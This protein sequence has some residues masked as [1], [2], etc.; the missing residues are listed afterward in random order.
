MADEI[1]VKKAK[2]SDFE[3]FYSLFQKT[4]K[5]G[6]FLY[7]P[8]SVKTFET[9]LPKATIR[10]DIGSGKRVLFL[11]YIN[12]NLAGY[13]LTNDLNGGVLFGHWLAVDRDFQKRGVA[14]K[15][16]EFWQKYAIAE[17]AHMLELFTTKNDVEFYINRGFILAGEL[18]DSYY[19]IDH[20]H[21]YKTLRKSDESRFLKKYEKK[22]K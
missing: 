20:F 10:K 19:G 11:A 3:D 14:S 5:E 22:K 21:F 13:L 16:L 12:S 15:L 17:G 8:R 1:I 4:L 9:D 18:P 2:V 7:S 6:Y